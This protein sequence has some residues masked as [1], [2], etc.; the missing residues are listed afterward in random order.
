[1]VKLVSI[2]ANPVPE[3]AVVGLV[4]TPDGT[5]IR[6]ARWPAPRDRKGTVCVFH[7]RTEFIEKYFEVVRDLV[8]R[9][10][11]VATFDWRGQ[12]L[13]DRI[14]REPRKGHISNFAKY[15]ID[16]ETFMRE[17]VLPD[18]PPPLFGLAN[19]MGAAVLMRAAAQGN[20]WFDRLV[21]CAP[22]IKLANI[23]LLPAVRV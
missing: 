17:V 9:G 2:P 12:G 23:P 1:M 21:L 7:G 18:C 3:G 22:M 16:L 5:S 11:A 13:S 15:G 14:L 8:A 19:S 10:F 4:K 6:F 20:R